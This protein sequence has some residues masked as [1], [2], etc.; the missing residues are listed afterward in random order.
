MI[1]HLVDEVTYT[2][3][4]RELQYEGFGEKQSVVLDEKAHD[5]C[6]GKYG[7]GCGG[8]RVF[9]LFEHSVK[10]YDMQT[11]KV[12]VLMTDLQEPKKITKNACILQVLTQTQT[13]EFNLSTMT[14]EFL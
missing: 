4:E 11:D 13:I 7:D 1:K 5:F 8:G 14:K 12:V 6:V 2:L 10:V 3:N 9:V